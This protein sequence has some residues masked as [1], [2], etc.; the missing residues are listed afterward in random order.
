[1]KSH[2][3]IQEVAK[4]LGRSVKTVRR[5]VSAG[6]IPAI[7]EGGKGTELRF[8]LDEVLQSVKCASRAPLAPP[9]PNPNQEK[10]KPPGPDGWCK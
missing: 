5:R 9:K 4:L 2:V 8:D 7:Q 3:T 1:M 6:L 10:E